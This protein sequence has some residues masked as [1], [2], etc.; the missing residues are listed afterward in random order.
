MASWPQNLDPS[1]QTAVSYILLCLRFKQP[2]SATLIKLL[3]SVQDLKGRG[4]E[5]HVEPLWGSTATGRTVSAPSP[6]P[7]MPSIYLSLSSISDEDHYSPA[8][9][10]FSPLLR[11]SMWPHKTV[12]EHFE[13]EFGRQ[14]LE[15]DW[16][17][18][19]QSAPADLT[20]LLNQV[21]KLH[22]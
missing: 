8:S 13:P 14:L 20:T 2:A 7:Q 6:P 9:R 4:Q 18:S 22:H 10:R 12:S 3:Y 17:Q 11:K 15:E 1:A 16:A 5:G 19:V 21:L